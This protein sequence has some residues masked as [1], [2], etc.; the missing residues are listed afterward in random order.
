[1]LI[2]P[3]LA[4]VHPSVYPSVEQHRSRNPHILSSPY[5]QTS[6]INDPSSNS[7]YPASSSLHHPPSSTSSSS[8]PHPTS[9]ARPSLLG[10]SLSNCSSTTIRPSHDTPSSSSS[11]FAPPF[12]SQQ[13]IMPFSPRPSP[14]HS[15]PYQQQQQQQAGGG[16]CYDDTNRMLGNLVLERRRAM[17]RRNV[18]SPGGYEVE[19]EE[20]EMGG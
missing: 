4:P 2:V 5:P 13:T 12:S 19:A 9:Y 6:L 17:G 7:P 8:Q 16:A 3:P 10:P 20:E 18:L 11:P 1:M 15:C 14:P